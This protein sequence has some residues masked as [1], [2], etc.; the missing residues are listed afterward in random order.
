MIISPKRIFLLISIVPEV[1]F[2]QSPGNKKRRCKQAY[3][4]ECIGLKKG[5]SEPVGTCEK[6]RYCSFSLSIPY[7]ARLARACP[8]FRPI[9]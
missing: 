5:Q 9:H 7:E 3:F 2:F 8:D 6:Q 4:S 1:F